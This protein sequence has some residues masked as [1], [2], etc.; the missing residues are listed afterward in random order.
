MAR[1]SIVKL[2]LA[3]LFVDGVEEKIFVGEVRHAHGEEGAG[4]QRD[5]YRRRKWIKLHAAKF[6]SALMRVIEVSA[7]GDGTFAIID[8]G[9]RWAMA[10]IAKKTDL[11][12]RVHHGLTREEEATLFKDFDKEIY[13]LRGIDTFLAMIGAKDETALAIQSAVLPYG[14]AVAGKGTLKCVGQFLSVKKGSPHGLRLLSS[15]AN[16]LATAYGNYDPK[17]GEF[18]K[19]CGVIDGYIVIAYATILDSVLEAIEDGGVP[20]GQYAAWEKRLAFIASRT[21]PAKIAEHLSKGGFLP[22]SI[23]AAPLA[24]HYLVNRPVTSGVGKDPAPVKFKPTKYDLG[25]NRVNTCY[26]TGKTFSSR[27][28]ET[29]AL[30]EDDPADAA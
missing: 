25:A 24:A 8:G 22:K 10:Q 16:I 23:P 4:Y 11:L 1:T 20:E 28:S 17:T 26:S 18:G 6:N 15:V 2:P 13:R 21:A 7:R 30:N 9:G 14:I 5:P 19:G 3:K 27:I 29:T 12:C